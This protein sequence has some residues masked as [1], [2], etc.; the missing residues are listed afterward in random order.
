MTL[1]T[2]EAASLL[3]CP[4][5]EIEEIVEAPEGTVIT[6]PDGSSYVD[7]PA[8][9]PDGDGKTGLMYRE[10][11]HIDYQGTFP[12]YTPA[13]QEAIPA[14]STPGPVDPP[15]PAAI[16]APETPA[17]APVPVRGKPTKAAG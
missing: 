4:A 16:T 13:P 14:E 3:G 1:T 12:V 8:D 10:A 15:E 11:P 6:M 17:E 9:R 5:G 7:V 2:D